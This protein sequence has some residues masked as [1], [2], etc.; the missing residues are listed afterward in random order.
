MKILRVKVDKSSSY[1]VR[2]ALL[3]ILNKDGEERNI[4][5]ETI[6]GVYREDMGCTIYSVSEGLDGLSRI[7]LN[8]EDFN[9]YKINVKR[10]IIE[11]EKHVTRAIVAEKHVTRAIVADSPGLE[12]AS[13][14]TLGSTLTKNTLR[15][16]LWLV[17][18]YLLAFVILVA[19][20]ILVFLPFELLELGK[21]VRGNL[22]VFLAI[23]W[24]IAVFFAIT[25]YFHKTGFLEFCEKMLD[26]KINP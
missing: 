19:E 4:Y 13:V 20:Y 18:F 15:F 2:T 10:I 22:N 14:A 3:T 24:G 5:V 1:S 12:T 21:G 8:K 6:D 11:A 17:V 16:A 7:K 26:K 23:L 9:D 25:Y